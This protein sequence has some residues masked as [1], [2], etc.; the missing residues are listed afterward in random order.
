MLSRNVVRLALSVI[1]FLLLG[2]VERG[3][4]QPSGDYSDY[5]YSHH[6]FS[7]ETP[8]RITYIKPSTLEPG[9]KIR[10]KLNVVTDFEPDKDGYLT[11]HL[12]S[13]S[14]GVLLMAIGGTD[15]QLIR[16]P[17]AR[18]TNFQVKRSRSTG[19]KAGALGGAVVG[20]GIAFSTNNDTPTNTS[21]FGADFHQMEEAT[22]GVL[23]VVGSVIAGA[24]LGTA[25][26]QG[27]WNDVNLQYEAY[28][29]AGASGHDYRLSWGLH[30]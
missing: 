24:L 8:E 12:K 11:G 9:A 16:V 18:I 7:Q 14:D 19:T 26:D 10:V 15:G 22:T 4:C 28:S 23:I 2:M 13:V 5:D 27:G 21:G 17:F 29:Q 6:G 30:F 25:L 3:I 20:L 1:V